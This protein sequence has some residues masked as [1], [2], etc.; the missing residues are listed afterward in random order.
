MLFN[1]GNLFERF[2]RPNLKVESWRKA[3][4]SPPDP[5]IEKMMADAA[6][7]DAEIDQRIAELKR[8]FSPC[9]KGRKWVAI[10]RS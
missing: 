2:N 4:G 1:G 3:V 7:E 8:N 10:V 9:F 6:I 5:R